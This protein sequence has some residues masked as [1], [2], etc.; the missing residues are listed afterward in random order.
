LTAES[1]SVLGYNETTGNKM[2]IFHLEDATAVDIEI[3]GEGE[4]ILD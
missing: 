2:M 1:F 3:M 4:N